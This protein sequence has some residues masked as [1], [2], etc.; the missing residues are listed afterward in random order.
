MALRLGAAWVARCA[1]PRCCVPVV[2]ARAFASHSGTVK[3]FSA[4]KGYGF[5]TAEDQQE[6]FVHFSGIE[7]DGFRSLADGESVEFD[8]EPDRSGKQK[9]V[10]VTGPGG[11]RV[12]GAPSQ[13]QGQ[14]GGGG[15]G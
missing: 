5:I 9:A 12:Q 13:G 15:F 6:Y 2:A 7:A 10:R 1:V 8:V 4:E 3:F 14:R 11:A